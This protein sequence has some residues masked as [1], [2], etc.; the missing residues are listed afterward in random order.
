M[1]VFF[2]RTPYH[3]GEMGNGHTNDTGR[4]TG[5]RDR[6]LDAGAGVRLR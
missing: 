5:V 4:P 1:L 2:T 3:L 6:I